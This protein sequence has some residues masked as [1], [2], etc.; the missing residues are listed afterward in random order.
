MAKEPVTLEYINQQIT[1]NASAYIQQCEENYKK[2]IVSCVSS[3]CEKG[4]RRLIMLAGPSSSGKTTTACLIKEEAKKHSR[5][6][7]VISL[8]DFY[9]DQKNTLYFEDGTPDFETISAL[10]TDYIA[11]CLTSLLK[12]GECLL[13][14]FNFKTKCREEK[15]E[16]VKIEKD[17]IVI[18]EGLHAINPFI[19]EHLPTDLLTK[20]YVSVSSR[21]M[22]D[23]KVL[24]TK[25]DLRFI[26]RMIRDYHHRNAQV[27][28]TFQL[29]KGVRM[30]EDRYLFPFSTL[31][32][33]KIDSIHPY[34]PC[35]FK[36]EAIKLLE[37]ID[38]NSEYYAQAQ[39]LIGKLS[40]FESVPRQLLPDDS[41]LH[42]FI[43]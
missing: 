33:A 4:G 5:S 8:D 14:R 18:V 12:S 35:L 31:A 41:L 42:E 29:W 25:R 43:G 9:K 26:R 10:D 13:P 32:D 37:H 17:E 24:L 11:E 39:T 38:E 6:A 20:L 2:Q 34:E 16:Q 28:Y 36:N 22:H 19:T 3:V 7:T 21:I 40:M 1:A 30:G 23:E 15:L 27:D